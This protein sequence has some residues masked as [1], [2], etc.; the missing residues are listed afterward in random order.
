VAGNPDRT[1]VRACADR[2]AADRATALKQIERYDAAFAHARVGSPRGSSRFFADVLTVG[3]ALNAMQQSGSLRVSK[4][5]STAT[6][7]PTGANTIVP[8]S[9]A[10]RGSAARRA[11]C[12]GASAVRA[13]ALLASS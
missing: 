4:Q 12:G 8:S 9:T 7:A 5:R 13:L 2:L 1:D 3:V 6:R 10:E 11:A